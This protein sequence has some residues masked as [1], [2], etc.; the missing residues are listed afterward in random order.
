MSVP[1]EL[2]WLV[3]IAIPLLLGL[4]VGSIVRKSIKI[5]F[6]IVALLI[7]LVATG[8]ITLSYQD[9]FDEAMSVLPNVID[10]GQG[11]IDSLPYSSSSFLIGLALGLWKG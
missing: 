2:A 9:I 10:T 11:F 8:Y 7:V 5:V 4:F 1:V 6:P 3:P